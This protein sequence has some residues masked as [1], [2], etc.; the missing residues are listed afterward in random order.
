MLM[1]SPDPPGDPG[2][3]LSKENSALFFALLVNALFRSRSW[4]VRQIDASPGRQRNDP[5]LARLK[6]LA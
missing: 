2:M 3:T 6:P 4:R 1:M 5:G